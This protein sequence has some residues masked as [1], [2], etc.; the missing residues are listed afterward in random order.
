MEFLSR[1]IGIRPSKTLR[2]E[3]PV[4]MPGVIVDGMVY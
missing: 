3:Q 1:N 4:A 2:Q